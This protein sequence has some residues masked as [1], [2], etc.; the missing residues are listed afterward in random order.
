[1]R[2]ECERCHAQATIYTR[3][4]Q[5]DTLSELFCS[6]KNPECGH[7]FVMDLAFSRTISPSALDFPS[8]VQ[9]QIQNLSKI[10]IRQLLAGLGTA[11]A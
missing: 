2:I 7:S 6:C 9:E 1:M 10:Q 11:S 4:K 5:S 3:K 8:G